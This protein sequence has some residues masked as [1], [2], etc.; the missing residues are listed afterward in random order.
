MDLDRGPDPHRGR[1]GPPRPAGQARHRRGVDLRRRVRHARRPRRRPG[2]PAARAWPRRPAPRW[3][4]CSRTSAPCRTRWTSPGRRSS[5]RA[6]SPGASR[7]W[8]PTRRSAW[9]RSST[10]LPWQGD[11]RPWPGQVLA[12][13][14]GAGA[15]RA[16][17]PVVCV[18]QVMQPVTGYT[19][20]VMAQAGIPYAIPGLRTPRRGPAQ[21]RLVVRGHGERDSNDGRALGVLDRPGRH[22]HRRGGP[23]PR[24]HARGAQAAVGEPGRLRRPGGGR[25]QAP[26]RHR[27][28][29]AIPAERIAVVRLG[30]TVATNA[31]L[32]RKGEP[33]VLVI[34]QGFADALRIAY[35]DRPRIFDRQIIRPD[36]LYSRVI[37]ATERVGAHGEVLVPLDAGA[38]AAGLQ[39]AYD[40][41]F[42]SVAVVCLHGYRYPAHE[43]RIGEIATRDRVHPGVAVPR[44]QPADEAGLPRRHHGGGRLPVP[45]PGPLRGQRHRGTARG[46]AAVHAVPRRPGRARGRSAA[47]TRSCPARPAASWAWPAPPRRR[48][49]AG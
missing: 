33:C 14:I 37:E 32:E 38:V 45:G 19:R 11:G 15:A 4:R 24:R 1:G 23:P 26:A 43:A 8:P 16:K 3:P 42:R 29:A 17:T 39:A 44:D 46:A 34:T 47:R 35:Q 40:D 41:G 31:L 27:A 28:R 36:L 12:D 6:S 20:A 22:V 2:R 18:S 5:T 13:A 48:G 10:R 21:H 7:S 30:T 9:S 49:S 25:H